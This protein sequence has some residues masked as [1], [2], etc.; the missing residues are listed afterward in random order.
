MT[1]AKLCYTRYKG[2]FVSLHALDDDYSDGLMSRGYVRWQSTPYQF[3]VDEDLQAFIKDGLSKMGD[4]TEERFDRFFAKLS[5]EREPGKRGEGAVSELLR[6][7]FRWFQRL[8]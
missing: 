2:H 7:P 6:S 3:E 4:G 1:N 8:Q 5:L